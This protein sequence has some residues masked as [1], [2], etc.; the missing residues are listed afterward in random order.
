MGRAAGQ[1][2]KS[3]V[4]PLPGAFNIA[5]LV[6]F[7]VA[8]AFATLDHLYAASMI[9]MGSLSLMFL[10]A[11]IKLQGATSDASKSKTVREMLGMHMQ[12]GQIAQ[13]DVEHEEADFRKNP[14]EMERMPSEIAHQ[15]ETRVEGFLKRLPDYSLIAR[16]NNDAG[17]TPS[18]PPQDMEVSPYI[19]SW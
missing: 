6:P 10:V 1:F 8:A 17:L 12:M 4:Q 7:L 16:F 3:S 5:S 13:W 19:D 9:A 2:L 11:G 18:A 14:R 15:W